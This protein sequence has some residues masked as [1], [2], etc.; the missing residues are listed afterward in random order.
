MSE[1]QLIDLRNVSN[2]TLERWGKLVKTWATG[3]SYFADVAVEKL[4][5]P[6]SIDELKRQLRLVGAAD[7]VIPASITGLTIIQHSTST[8]VVKLP[9]K[10]LIKAKEAQLSNDPGSYPLPAFYQDIL[11]GKFEA[12]QA[13]AW[14]TGEYTIQ[15][16]G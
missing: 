9:P 2:S 15:M 6:R 1:H 13:H 10:E 7:L 16:C 8:M 11:A 4:P 14:R 3:E 12:L 5:I